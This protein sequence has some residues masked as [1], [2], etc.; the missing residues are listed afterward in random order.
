MKKTLVVL[1]LVAALALSLSAASRE[2]IEK[3]Q[4]ILTEK[5]MNA[6]LLKLQEFEKAYGEDKD[7][8]TTLMHLHYADTYFKMANYAKSV[9]WAEKSLTFKNVE[10]FDKM[11]LYLNLANSFNQ[12]GTPADKEKSYSYADMLLNLG[13]TIMTGE[14][15]KAQEGSMIARLIKDINPRYVVPALRIQ[16]A[17][18]S[19]RGKDVKTIGDAL[20]KSI[21]VLT[22]DKSERSLKTVFNFL[23]VWLKDK[24]EVERT[25]QTL[26][27]ILAIMPNAQAY[28]QLGVM[29][30]KTD[31]AKS[32]EYFKEAYKLNKTDKTA[33]AL[34]T[35]SFQLN[36]D[37]LQTVAN[38][39]AEAW[40]LN[41][42]HSE[43]PE[44]DETMKQLTALA[45]NLIAKP[46][47]TVTEEALKAKKDELIQA[48]RERLGKN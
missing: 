28:E 42:N 2:K 16:L 48:A 12:L 7:T 40:V 23:S 47:E 38:Y 13:K 36:K 20:E 22:I 19:G 15:G 10:D 31:K 21:E 44:K 41:P 33:R 35:L 45:Q 11:N 9:E 26:H 3:W 30:S 39:Y 29:V 43:D 46:G 27:R 1:L 6:K 5:D 17:I 24:V 4:G 37:D 25:M 18:L 8:Y 14:A 34:A 32:L